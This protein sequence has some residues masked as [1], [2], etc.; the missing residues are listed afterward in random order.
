MHTGEKPFSCNICNKSFATK[1]MVVKHVRVHTGEKPYV[2]NVCG[3]A[4]SQSSSLN[5]H[6]KIH[7]RNKSISVNGLIS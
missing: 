4:F 6:L 1:T 5:T 2:C 7:S 3:K